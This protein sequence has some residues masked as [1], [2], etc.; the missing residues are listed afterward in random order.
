MKTEQIS[1]AFLSRAGSGETQLIYGLDKDQW[2]KTITAGQILKGRVL[3]V[4]SEKKYG[5]DF[6]GQ[7]R[8]V[9][10]TIPLSKGEVL[11]GKVLG[12]GEHNISMKIVNTKLL[13]DLKNSK[14]LVTKQAEDK[15]PIEIESAK[16]KVDLDSAMQAAIISASNG[17]K[18]SSVA[19]RVGLYLAKLGIPITG[20]LVRA[21][22]NRVLN[23]QDFFGMDL[24]KRI[25]ILITESDSVE[26]GKLNISTLE[27]LKNFF[28][29]DF[30]VEFNNNRD[31]DD[32]DLIRQASVMTENRFASAGLN[33]EQGGANN[34]SKLYKLFEKILNVSTGSSFQHRFQTLPLIIDGRLVEFDVAFFDQAAQES[35]NGLLKSKRI[36]F[37]LTTEFGFINLD[38]IA[39]NHRLNVSLS[40]N[41][42]FLVS[43]FVEYE[44][45]LSESLVGAGWI[46]DSIQYKKA[47]EQNI[48]AYEVVK[49]VLQQ[50]SLNITA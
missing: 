34:K 31:D 20:E 4:Y 1:A 15:L 39:V 41:N 25:P 17:F 36:K 13:E 45:D 46:L 48:A 7:E 37:S 28:L 3:R 33:A 35:S 50:E 11:T 23:S 2:L 49:H 24:S 6:G 42:D 14:P 27:N 44:L 16:F 12:V 21:L 30:D 29:N 18:N 9:D 43:Q 22:T 38:V 26:L 8:I 47:H 19:I 10:S 5:V 40:S 32:T